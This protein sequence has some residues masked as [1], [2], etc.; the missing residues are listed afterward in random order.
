MKF[1]VWFKGARIPV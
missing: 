1:V